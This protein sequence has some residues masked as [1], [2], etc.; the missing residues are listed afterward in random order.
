MFNLLEQPETDMT[1]WLFYTSV[2][3]DYPEYVMIYIYTGG[4]NVAL[5]AIVVVMFS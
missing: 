5:I 2:S 3:I 1:V 4:T